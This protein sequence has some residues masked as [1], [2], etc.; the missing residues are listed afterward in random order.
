MSFFGINVKK[1]R[2]V[3]KISQAEFASLFGLTR[4]AVG[5]YEEGRAEAKIDKTIEIAE[6]YGLTLEQFLKKKLTLNEIFHYDAKKKILNF[7]SKYVPIHFVEYSKQKQYIKNTNNKEFL[8][9]LPK[10]SFPNTEPQQRAFEIRNSNHFLDGDILICEKSIEKILGDNY[11]LL[12]SENGMK[13]LDKIPG[14]VYYIEVWLVKFVISGNISKFKI[15]EQ[16]K[17]LI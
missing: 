9:R 6:Y 11:Y 16:L 10:I 13:I 4:S 1:I 7:D 2:T 17:K 8:E 3:K 5:A 12:I 14:K 15:L